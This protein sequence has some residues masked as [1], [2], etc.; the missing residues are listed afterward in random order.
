MCP[1]LRACPGLT[2]GRTLSSG[3]FSTLL[4]PLSVDCHADEM[5]VTGEAVGAQMRRTLRCVP[6][7]LLVRKV[8]PRLS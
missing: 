8:C 6:W 7:R 1:G 2:E 5:R 4:A 3:K